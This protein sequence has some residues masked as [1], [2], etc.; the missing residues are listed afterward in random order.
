MDIPHRG[1]SPWKRFLLTVSI[2]TLWSLSGAAQ[3]TIIPQP[4]IAVVG[5]DVLLSLHGLQE[6]SYTRVTWFE[7]TDFMKSILSYEPE[8]GN[9]IRGPAFTNQELLQSNSSL[10]IKGIQGT[11]PRYFTILV[12]SRSSGLL[13]ATG[14]FQVYEEPSKPR[15]SMDTGSSI[16]EF[17]SSM[18]LTCDTEDVDVIIRW[19][20]NDT[21]LLFHPQLSLSLDNRT[22]TFHN[23]TRQDSGDYYCEASNP[24]GFQSSDIISV[25]VYYGPDQITITPDTEYIRGNTIGVEMNFNLGLTCQAESNPA[26]NYAWYLNESFLGIFASNYHISGASKDQG[27]SYKCT[28]ENTQTAKSSSA[29]VTVKVVERVTKPYML[30]NDTSIVEGKGAVMFTCDTPDSEIEVQWFLNNQILPL[31]D[32]LVLSQENRTLT[33]AQVQREDAGQYQC[34]AS[35]LIFKNSS[36][37]VALTVNYGP[38]PINITRESGSRVV[39]SIETQL[40]S[41]LTLLC[42]ADSQPAA[43]YH[44]SLNS[45]SSLE[46]NGSLF[47]IEAVTWDH[48]GTC[49]CLAWNDLTQ[50][51]RSATVTISVFDSSL[52]AEVIA[53]IVIGVLVAIALAVGLVYFLA[54]RKRYTGDHVEGGKDHSGQS[55]SVSIDALGVQRRVTPA[56]DSTEDLF[57]ENKAPE[58]DKPPRRRALVPPAVRDT[59]KEQEHFYENKAPEDDKPPRRRALVPPAV[60]DTSKEQEHFYEKLSFPYTD[61]YFTIDPVT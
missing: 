31:S 18:R 36:E 44:W 50:M 15:I 57:Y 59:S 34:T 9:V 17:Q 60:R 47:T 45:T 14:G 10:I 46:Q 54:I 4:S 28:V 58:D 41:A 6:G 13:S 20:L 61:D 21:D 7:G 51:L 8:T 30:S 25:I 43:L 53:G 22:L 1:F 3:L 39:N 49:T 40:G 55:G 23:V 38:D 33:I 29:S 12:E 56:K 19:L 35:N 2:L 37:P 11:G 27:G 32:R 26:P 52:S 5:E 24:V 42:Q 48:Q 16:I